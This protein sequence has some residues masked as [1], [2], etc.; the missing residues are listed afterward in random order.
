[1]TVDSVAFRRQSSVQWLPDGFVQSFQY[2]TD[3]IMREYVAR[4]YRCACLPG[5]KRVVEQGYFYHRSDS[6]GN[7]ENAGSFVMRVIF[8]MKACAANILSKGSRCDQS[9]FPAK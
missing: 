5:S 9:N 7:E 2:R 8:S 3:Q 4:H 1:M 6:H